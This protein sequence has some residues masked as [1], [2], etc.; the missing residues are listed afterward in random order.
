MWQQFP[1]AIQKYT[2][3]ANFARFDFTFLIL[4]HF[5]T[6]HCN[7]THFTM[8]SGDLFAF[9][10]LVLKLLCIKWELSINRHNYKLQGQIYC[11]R[12]GG[13]GGGGGGGGHT[14]P[15]DD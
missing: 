11:G 1:H 3:F 8:L 2:K 10:C 7:F 12:A 15:S 13:G 14:Q 4:Q 9:P 6:K 5:A